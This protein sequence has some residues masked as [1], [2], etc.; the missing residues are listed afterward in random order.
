MVRNGSRGRH[1]PIHEAVRTGRFTKGGAKRLT[2][3]G[4]VVSEELR[5]IIN[6]SIYDGKA[7]KG[8]PSSVTHILTIMKAL[9]HQSPT[10]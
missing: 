1:V 3:E 5:D 7:V 10:F 4:A 2:R 9:R 6:R 8:M